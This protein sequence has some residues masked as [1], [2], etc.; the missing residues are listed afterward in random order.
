MKW[1]YL[2]AII[3]HGEGA[4]S[5]IL[6]A[7]DNMEICEQKWKP[8]TIS[9]IIRQYP[10]RMYFIDCVEFEFPEQGIVDRVK[11]VQETKGVR[12]PS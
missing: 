10:G 3:W 11:H 7:M 4:T 8:E 5:G 9:E 6:R 12:R 2:V 1:V